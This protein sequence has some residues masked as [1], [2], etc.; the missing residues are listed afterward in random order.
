MLFNEYDAIDNTLTAAD[1]HLDDLREI[2][3]NNSTLR[4]MSEYFLNSLGKKPAFNPNL[5]D[6]KTAEEQ[7]Q[8]VGGISQETWDIMH[9]NPYR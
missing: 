3:E 1:P 9:R 4:P 6:E 2:I 8:C 7:Q 5:K